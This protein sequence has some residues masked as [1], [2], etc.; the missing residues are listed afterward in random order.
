[1]NRDEQQQ[2]LVAIKASSELRNAALTA[3]NV[4]LQAWLDSI[5]SCCVQTNSSI[6][7][8]NDVLTEWA[9]V[10]SAEYVNFLCQLQDEAVIDYQVV[11]ENYI[12]QQ[13][14]VTTTTSTTG[15]PP[16]TTTT[17]I[18]PD[19][20]EYSIVFDGYSCM[21]WDDP[22]EPDIPLKSGTVAWVATYNNYLCALENNPL[23]TTTTT[24]FSGTTTT[25]TTVDRKMLLSLVRLQII[26]VS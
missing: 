6:E 25:S 12:C 21:Q 10:Y 15:M 13:T 16:T 20:V 17:T 5:N 11:F 14:D 4:A 9:A 23:V 3:R 19:L 7:E 2:I 22:D 26:Y 8:K 18:D 24:T 1:M